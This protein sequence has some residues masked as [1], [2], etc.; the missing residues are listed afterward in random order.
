MPGLPY[1]CAGHDMGGEA[2]SAEHF[3]TAGKGDHYKSMLT[4][5]EGSASYVTISTQLRKSEIV[6]LS[7]N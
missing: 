1:F 4:E 2:C 3:C 7:W 5:K 6:N